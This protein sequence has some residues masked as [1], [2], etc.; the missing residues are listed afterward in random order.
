VLT[1][2]ISADEPFLILWFRA[3]E[4]EVVNWAGNPHK[5]VE[6]AEGEILSPR[7][8][9]EAWSDTVRGRSRPWRPA[10]TEAAGRLKRA[11]MDVR[12]NRRLRDLNHRLNETLADKDALLQQKEFLLQEVNHRIQN[13]LQLVS[14]FLGLQARASE[15]PRLQEAIEEARR[16]L[17]AVALVHR[18]LYR[19]DQIENVDLARYIEELSA[20]MLDSMDEEWRGQVTLD[21]APIL[22]PTDRAV[23][24]GLVLTELVINA[25]KYAYGG[26]PGPIEISLEQ[27]RNAFRLIVADR[28]QGKLGPREGFGSRMMAA[29]VSQLSGELEQRDNKPGL[30]AILTAPITPAR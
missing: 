3:E 22:I 25:N 29:M 2:T 19:A 12:Q 11:L 24:L 17:S 9:F 5:A 28:G 18:R 4:V 13:S 10:E 14:S 23:T 20:E 1:V 16:R 21:L 26:R 27:H 8:S 30:R 15:D 6:L 7:A